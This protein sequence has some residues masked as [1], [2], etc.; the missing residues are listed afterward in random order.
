[1]QQQAL[2][3]IILMFT[4]L[5]DGRNQRSVRRRTILSRALP[6]VLAIGWTAGTARV[7]AEDGLTAHR[8]M[9]LEALEAMPPDLAA[10]FREHA[11][12]LQL[13]ATA[14][15]ITW[16]EHPQFRRRRDW[17]FLQ[18]DVGLTEPSREARLQAL[19]DY[20]RDAKLAERA[21]RKAGG[22]VC[23]R[24]PWAVEECYDDLV[25]AFRT[26]DSAG[27]V[28][29]AG[30]LLHFVADAV[31]PFRCTTTESGAFAGPLKMDT[32]R[33]PHPTA[34]VDTV[35]DRYDVAVLTDRARDY[36]LAVQLDPTKFH[37]KDK[38][39][40]AVFEVLEDS[41]LVLEELIEADAK[42]TTELGIV[43]RQSFDAQRA[44]YVQAVDEHVGRILISR[45]E[46]GA[47][48]AADLIGGA[49]KAA[50]EPSKATLDG[51]VAGPT[52]ASVSTGG[53]RAF[54]GSKN[55]NVYHRPD[56]RFAKQIGADNLVG[57]GSALEAQKDGRRACRMCA[58]K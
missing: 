20:P 47:T 46:A 12:Q 16:D 7:S 14:P 22:R 31:D 25:E 5:R 24:L 3:E 13:H 40:E 51:R 43:D 6:V 44:A 27:V 49:W 11:E 8:L 50:G 9:A 41:L 58:P 54:V 30:F 15:G 29:A 19:K 37:P 53:G 21:C 26:G 18:V 34:A 38:P 33:E 36:A 45:I 56:C 39:V 57:Y 28:S 17:H 4:V 23:G 52:G 1:M 32:P 10:V 42:A 48:L 2:G 35:R 55:S